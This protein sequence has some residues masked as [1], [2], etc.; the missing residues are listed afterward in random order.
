MHESGIELPKSVEHALQI[1]QDTGTD[2][3]Q[4]AIEKEMKNIWTV[5]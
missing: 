5:F 2:Y 4:Q 3:W 1:N